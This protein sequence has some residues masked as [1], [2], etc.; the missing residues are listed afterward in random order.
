MVGVDFKA[1][2]FG[3]REPRRNRWEHY[4]PFRSAQCLGSVK[5]CVVEKSAL[6]S[7]GHGHAF[8]AALDRGDQLRPVHQLEGSGCSIGFGVAAEAARRDEKTGV[9]SC[10]D[11]GGMQPQ[12]M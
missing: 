2:A 6:I 3:S 1:P 10:G 7:F 5:L 4:V 8:H 12:E 9:G 11:N